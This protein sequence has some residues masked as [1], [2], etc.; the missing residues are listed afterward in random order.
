M[1]KSLLCAVS[2]F[3]T[4][5]LGQAAEENTQTWLELS[6]YSQNVGRRIH[7]FGVDA[8]KPDPKKFEKDIAAIDVLLDG[9]VK[10]GVLKNARFELKPE[11]EIEESLVISVAE[12]IKTSCWSKCG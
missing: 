10:K 6:V 9:L 3:S 4:F 8:D 7:M 2:L 5:T 11:L 1:L 12:L